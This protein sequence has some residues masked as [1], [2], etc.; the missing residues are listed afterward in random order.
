MIS[1]NDNMSI[2]TG[3]G[4]PMD[5]TSRPSSKKVKTKHPGPKHK[6]HVHNYFK[7]ITEGHQCQVKGPNNIN[8][9]GYIIKEG[10]TTSNRAHHLTISHK[11]LSSQE[12]ERVLLLFNS[13]SIN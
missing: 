6:S 12:K 7:E 8:I 5:T 4:D 9:C 3:T 13:N 11:I 10:E 1:L 2:D